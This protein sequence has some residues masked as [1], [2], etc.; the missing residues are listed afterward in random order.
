M[1]TQTRDYTDRSIKHRI[2]S[3]SWRWARNRLT[4]DRDV[5]LLRRGT[6]KNGSRQNSL[7]LLFPYAD[8]SIFILR[9][10]FPETLCTLFQGQ[11]YFRIFFSLVCF[12]FP[13][14]AVF[15]NGSVVGVCGD[16]YDVEGKQWEW[17]NITTKY[18]GSGLELDEHFVLA[19]ELPPDPIDQIS[20]R[21]YDRLA[22]HFIAFMSWPTSI[23]QHVH[24]ELKRPQKK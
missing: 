19:L 11:F 5:W 8:V 2:G 21:I 17:C 7:F 6:W 18:P 10:P 4:C 24:D 23:R 20:R 12:T 14:A 1:R 3:T 13:F 15:F 9:F 16:F 22:K